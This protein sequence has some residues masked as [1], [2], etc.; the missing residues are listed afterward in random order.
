MD[1]K[2]VS[3]TSD[4]A[5]FT[6]DMENCVLEVSSAYYGEWNV[7]LSDDQLKDLYKFLIKNGFDITKCYKEGE[8]II[9]NETP[10]I[11]KEHF[12]VEADPDFHYKLSKLP[13]TGTVSAKFIGWEPGLI[14]AVYNSIEGDLFPFVRLP[15]GAFK[16]GAKFVVSYEYVPGADPELDLYIPKGRQQ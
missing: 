8:N 12:V 15:G 3:T 7:I 11:I 10:A 1:K 16:V 2:T 9:K 5:M 14:L 13:K 4:D 6:W